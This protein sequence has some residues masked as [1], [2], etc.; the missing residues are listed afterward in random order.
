MQAMH[1]VD[2][3]DDGECCMCFTMYEEDIRELSGKEWVECACGQWLHE[4]CAEDC[5]LDNDGKDSASSALIFS[6]NTCHIL[7]LY[8]SAVHATY[9]HCTCMS[10]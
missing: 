7:C 1:Q 10:L 5:V 2:N 8:S 9:N 3:I 6:H 4:D